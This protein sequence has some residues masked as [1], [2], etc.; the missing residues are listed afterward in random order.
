MMPNKN[1]KQINALKVRIQSLQER[2]PYADGGAYYQDKQRIS[3][4][5][6]ELVAL[7]T[8]ELDDARTQ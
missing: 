7:Q 2:L 5:K 8:Q 3:E 6:R 1:Q 4:L